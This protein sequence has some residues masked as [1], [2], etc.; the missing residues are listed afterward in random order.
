MSGDEKTVESLSKRLGG[1]LGEKE[2]KKLD[3]A[4]DTPDDDEAEEPRLSE[5]KYD[6]QVTLADQQADPNSPLFS[7]KSFE[8]L[9][10]HEDLL[11]GIYAMKFTK[12]SKIQ[13]RALPLL[14]QN[15]PRNMIGQSQS[16]TGKT[17]AFVLT[18]LS[19]IDFSVQKPQ[20]VALAPSRELARQIMDVV[21]AMGRFTPVRTA[22]AIPDAIKRG[23][24]VD[25]HLVVGTPGKM[26]DLIKTRA[27]D[28]SAVKVFV[29]DEAD[30][31]LDQQGL[32]EQSI[33]VKNTM[34]RTCQVVLFSATFPDNVRTFAAKFAPSAN[35]IRLKQEELSVESIRQFYMD[36]RSEEHK[37]DVLVELYSLLTIG[38]SIIFCAKR[39]TAD[40]IAQRMTAEGHRVD[41]L[42]GKLDNAERD[43]TIDGFRSGKCKVLI[44]TNVIARG[45]DI[46]QVTLVVNYDMPL[47]QSGEPDTETYLHRI[48]RTGRF[49][50]RG[51]SINFV[52]DERS[53]EQ[54]HAIEK[55]LHCPIVAVPTDDVELM[56]QTIKDALK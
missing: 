45:I 17:A 13:E 40:R 9:G 48:G 32:G 6:V 50:R 28:P 27:L 23:E 24:R 21:Q 35:E 5:P 1:I 54:M 36:C 14:L 33:R 20:A 44:A 3:W 41:S 42:H 4:D 26:F 10:L 16:G 25:A 34:P 7:V 37:Y 55:A 46:Q 47:T 15:P 51:V 2:E 43:R 12:P 22:Y 31:M 29:L 38:Q 18:M 11:K 53:K 49:G 52:H 30:N 19:R 56:E 39:D 8:Q